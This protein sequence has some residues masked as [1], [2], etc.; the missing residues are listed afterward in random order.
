MLLVRPIAVLWSVLV[1]VGWNERQRLGFAVKNHPLTF[2]WFIRVGRVIVVLV[3]TEPLV[4][5]V[6]NAPPVFCW[7]VRLCFIFLR[8]LGHKLARRCF[9]MP[10]IN[11]RIS[12]HADPQNGFLIGILARVVTEDSLQV[13]LGV[14]FL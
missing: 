13:L 11:V 14:V 1:A 8:G 4:S 6:R 7:N 9:Q 5:G 3:V 2:V 10:L 12:E